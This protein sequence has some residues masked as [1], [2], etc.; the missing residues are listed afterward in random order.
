ME[1]LPY[2]VNNRVELLAR[3]YCCD[4][5]RHTTTVVIPT[6]LVEDKQFVEVPPGWESV[7]LSDWVRC[8][9][10]VQD[11]KESE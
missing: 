9:V 11:L 10:C 8:P 6:H 3:I 2:S 5:N 7:G 1:E 4:C